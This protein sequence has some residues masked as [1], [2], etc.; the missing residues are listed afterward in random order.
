[1]LPW[2]SSKNECVANIMIFWDNSRQPIFSPLKRTFFCRISWKSSTGTDLVTSPVVCAVRIFFD[3]YIALIFGYLL[4]K[5]HVMGPN[6]FVVIRVRKVKLWPSLW[7]WPRGQGQPNCVDIV[8]LYRTITAMNIRSLACSLLSLL[9]TRKCAHF[10]KSLIN[11]LSVTWSTPY[12]RDVLAI[13][14]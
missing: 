2:T 4:V 5:C 6:T 8:Y 9:A 3:E 14:T 12:S 11:P 7:P 10:R 1:M 13:I